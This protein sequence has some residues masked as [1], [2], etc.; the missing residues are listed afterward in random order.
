[1]QSGL[2]LHVVYQAPFRAVF[3]VLCGA[4]FSLAVVPGGVMLSAG[5]FGAIFRSACTGPCGSSM[6]SGTLEDTLTEISNTFGYMC[7]V[8]MVYWMM[9]DILTELKKVEKSCDLVRYR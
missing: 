2:T 6:V 5:S 8:Y 4:A 3:A 1:M 9:T 7:L